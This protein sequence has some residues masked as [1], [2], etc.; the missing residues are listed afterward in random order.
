MII[1]F[2]FLIVLVM[3]FFPMR[4]R[5]NGEKQ[6]YFL[7][8]IMFLVREL[9]VPYLGDITPATVMTTVLFF[10]T[11][12]KNRRYIQKW[13]GYSFCLLL[14]LLIGVITID[15]PEVALHW[16]FNLFVVMALALI[17]QRL[18]SEEEDLR[19]LAKCVLTACVVFSFSTII[20]YW[21][22]ADGSV[23]F[24][25][26]I[27]ETSNYYSSRIY[28]ITSS[29]L[30][31]IISVISIVLIPW[32]RIKKKWIELILIAMFIYAAL[33]TL[34]RM[35]FIAMIF[36]MLYYIYYKKKNNQP[37][38]VFVVIAICIVF[39]SLF[40]EPMMYRF[41]IAGFGGNEIEDHSAES[42]IYR[43]SLAY[44]AFKQSPLFGMGAGYVTYVHNGFMEILGN[45]GILG[46][47]CIFLRYIPSIKDIK[48]LNP[49]AITS[50]IYLITCFSLESA[51]NQAQ[52]LS[53]LGIFLGGYYY[54]L[55]FKWKL[56]N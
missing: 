7:T 28:G 11:F 26:E 15:K 23:I 14:S 34:K 45:C 33:I 13:A 49:W 44:S 29:N 24:A 51:I 32:L 22:Y 55:N 52:V 19:R 25:G 37:K 39:V 16:V 31:Q 8:V 9:N 10:S 6:Y 50:L 40:W 41:G 38:T 17:P 3:L 48:K 21:G 2:V 47:F 35:S 42:R 43:A 1:K 36:S 4:T 30:V 56:K 5:H 53:F 12:S 18:F 27:D 54:S 20:S 46:I